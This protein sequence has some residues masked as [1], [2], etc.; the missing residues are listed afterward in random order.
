MTRLLTLLLVLWTG[1][2]ALASSD[3]NDAADADWHS[4][5]EAAAED[6]FQTIMMKNA[7][8]QD[9]A[10][11]GAAMAAPASEATLPPR[12]LDMEMPTAGGDPASVTV[13]LARWAAV[14]RALAAARE[15]AG[16]TPPG[17]P[18]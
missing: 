8:Q 16:D 12:A 2:P 11:G 6:N 9:L 4:Q 10:E 13:D 1:A 14:R 18:S 7:F 15:S 5:R 17:S 3:T